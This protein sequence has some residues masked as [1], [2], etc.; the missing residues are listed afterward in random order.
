MNSNPIQPTAGTES[1]QS[2][3]KDVA[4][5]HIYRPPITEINNPSAI[6]NFEGWCSQ[7]IYAYVNND[8]ATLS[9]SSYSSNC[10]ADLRLFS[11]A[12]ELETIARNLLD[13][14]HYLRQ[15]EIGR[16]HV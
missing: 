2:A 13:A 6:V 1:A 8:V 10:L 3:I 11:N 9:A 4:F 15:Q 14:G 16:A 7:P 12:D 5:T